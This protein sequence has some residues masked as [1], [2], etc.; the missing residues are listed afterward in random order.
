MK[1]KRIVLLLAVLVVFAV[2]MTSCAFLSQYH[3]HVW[4]GGSCTEPRVC[5]VCHAVDEKALGHAE[6]TVTGYAATCTEDGLSD[7]TVCSICNTVV[8]AQEVI[9]ALGHDI[10]VDAAIDADCLN[11]GLTAGEHCSRCD[12]KVD[13]E[14]VPALGHDIVKDAAKAPTCTENGLT[15]GEHCTRCD[16]NSAQEV[17]PALGH[18]MVVDA[19]KAPTCTEDGLKE[20][21]HCSRCD[22]KVAQEVD[23]A[24]GHNIVKDEAKA[25]TCTETGLTEGEHCTRCDGATVAQQSVAALGHKYE[26]CVCTVC[27]AVLPALG[28]TDSFDFSTQA[29]FDS[30]VASG[31]LGFVGNFRN[32]GDSFQFNA[33]STIQ[34]VA[35]ANSIVTLTGH[36]AQYGVFNVS[37][38]GEV[39]KMAGTLTFTVTEETKV[40]ISVGD[41]G[42][43]Y[44]YIKGIALEAYVDRTITED[45]TINFGSEGN[46]KDS[47]VDFSGIQIGDNGGNNSQVKNGSFDLLL[48]AGSKVVIHGYPGYTSYQLNDGEEITAEW[49]TYIALTDTV[50][51]VTPVNGSNYF[52]SIEITLHQGVAQVEA[53]PADCENAGYEAYYSCT[54][55]G[56]LTTKVVVD[57]LGHTE[58]TLAGKAATCTEAGLTAGK[59]CSVC[60]KVLVAQTEI[61]AKGHTEETLAGKESTCT[62]AGLTEGKKCSVCGEILIKQQELPLLE[63]SYV[64]GICACG[65]KDPSYVNYHLVGFI[66]GADHGCEGDYMNPGEYKFVDG[67]LVAKFNSDSYVFVKS[68]N[69]DG[70]NV[71][72]YLT[73]QYE[74]GMEA[75]FVESGHEKLFVPGNV[76][77]EFTLTV[78]ADGSLKV[79]LEYHVHSYSEPT[80]TEP[81]KCSCGLTQGEATGHKWVDASFD[82]PKTCSKCG[83]T[84]GAALV[85]VATA[86]G[87]KYQT[88]AEALEKGSEIVLLA[89]IE[90]DQPLVLNGA[91]TI[92]LNGYTLSYTSEVMGE[93]MITNYGTLVINDS[94][95][96]GTI[97]YNYVGA[98]DA[99]Y[100]KGN[101]TISNHGHLTINGGKITIA[102]L[103]QHAKYPIDNN[104]GSSDAV[105]VINGGHLYNY[106][107]SAIR[108]ICSA[109]YNNSVTINGGLVEGYC[110]I[111]MQN[112]G[113]NTV[114]GELT[115]TGGE[116]RTTAAA[117][118][119]GTSALQDVSSRIYAT[120]EGGAWSETSFVKISGGTFNE[121]VE[122]VDEAPVTIISG[123][124][125]NGKIE[126]VHTFVGATCTADGTCGCGAVGGKL[127]HT[128]QTLA[129]KDATCT[130]TGLTAG[131]KCSVCGETL[132][133]QVE[134]PAKDHAYETIYVW[135]ADN[136]Y[137]TEK[138]VCKNDASHVVEGETVTVSHITLNVTASKVTYTYH[139][140][141]QTK[142]VESDLALENNIATIDA[143]AVEGRVASHD[144]VK[145]SFHEAAAT[146]EFTIY[147]SEVDVWD[148]TVATEFAGGSGTEEDPYIIMTGAQLAYLAK[149]GMDNTAAKDSVY[150][151]GVYYKLGANLDLS[152]HQW[153]PIAMYDTAYNWT[154]FNGN[155]DGDNH[156]IIL[157]INNESIGY[158]LFA[159]LGKTSVVKNLTL[160]GNVQAAHRVGALVFITQN[161]A[162]IENV[163]N[164]ANV[165]GTAT[166]GYVG[167]LVGA[168]Q[169]A[170]TV[171]TGCVNYGI[172]NS[173]G[174]QTGGLV[175]TTQSL[176]VSNCVNF[177]EVSCSAGTVGGIAGNGNGAVVT[178][179]CNYGA[180]SGGGTIGG[181]VG[182]ITVSTKIYN[183]TNYGTIDSTSYNSGG[184]GGYM[185]EGSVI[186]GCVNYGSVSATNEKTGGIIGNDNKGT[187]S[188]CKNYGTITGVNNIGG[189]AGDA[190]N[191][192]TGCVNYG[193]VKGSCISTTID[194]ICPSDVTKTDCA[195]NGSVVISEHNLTHT[196]AKAATC[197]ADGNVAY[198]YCSVC[199]K[200]Y[201]ADGKVIENVVINKTGHFYNDGVTE[202]GVTTYT[203]SACGDSYTQSS[204]YTVTVNYVDLDGT[205]VAEPE[206]IE[207]AYGE[208]ATINA[209]TIDNLVPSHDYVKVHV[210]GD[211]S[212]TIYYSP[213]DVWD[214]E[215]VS[216]GLQGSG[217]AEDPYLIQ[218][219]ADL[220][221]VAQTV[222]ALAGNKVGFTGK[223]MRLTKSIDLNGADFRIGIYVSG[224]RKGFGAYL[225]GNNCSIRGLNNT[226]SF[227]G[228]LEAGYV[229]NLSVYGITSKNDAYVGGLCSILYNKAY[230][231]N[232]T[233]YV[234]VSGR[235]AVAG[236]AGK[237]YAG[238]TVRNC[239]NYGAVNAT[240]WQSG[241]ITGCSLGDVDGCINFGTIFTE[242]T[243][244]GGISGY[245][246]DGDN[247]K[248]TTTNC[249]NY[250]NVTAN[251]AAGKVGGIAGWGNIVNNCYNYGT[252]SAP[253]ATS[254]VGGV[255][256]YYKTSS[257]GCVDYSGFDQ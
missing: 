132:E 77:V 15:A 58:E 159:G 90:L 189:I 149:L 185:G 102:N 61:A 169:G 151:T 129:G 247:G 25:P 256:G 60:Q 113:K 162:R 43:S 150:G 65:Y 157:N 124:T 146:Y 156:R 52:Y 143:P 135:A 230:I 212:V 170:N 100:G 242:G 186:D 68:V 33:D 118:V 231:E 125:F 207:F 22:H 177:G 27:Q 239:V 12:H 255:C 104:S 134:I 42:A 223:Y 141:E 41:N 237:I 112:P 105:L 211:S 206:A 179:C 187:V 9:P 72:W 166:G 79:V 120:V 257:E 126:H 16:Y 248:G 71:K 190:S 202:N 209:K 198:D 106:N 160:Y 215:T 168:V 252:V 116:I 108:M 14:E 6:E 40:V 54:C 75:T 70:V 29:G 172:V 86:D 69:L 145:F 11:S 17:V 164:Y 31:K 240:T 47:I 78:N 94:A 36:S 44:S 87:V 218:S 161:G 62:E 144:Y 139:A 92:E 195:E 197:E 1:T 64:S 45:T 217:T 91:Y 201:D 184:I 119:N 213:V 175:G 163:T 110:A 253:N 227:I 196:D 128:E 216:T 59:K 229:K 236:I 96:N 51:T 131:K 48:K 26:N 114:N 84:E 4:E 13:Q 173:A 107:T 167:G 182:N 191:E 74:T 82:A 181:I 117:Y 122:F 88:L 250:G 73:T 219:A 49:Y 30:A 53:K 19:A 245:S 142:V 67:K 20:G 152:N 56:E 158:G 154:Y 7:G 121:N 165:T 46:Y 188:N 99:S 111:W 251:G 221:Y 81:G 204:K 133:A 205:K 98:N 199:K 233:S 39:T 235:G 89:N 21:S 137:Y 5:S 24:L 109:N 193:V 103:R 226:D 63:H 210:Q 232:V 97:N 38:N 83:A 174:K 34:F 180:I 28:V 194:Q 32:N 214:G 93:A 123:G 8:V 76:E 176:N 254:Y 241:G 140:G 200:N 2:A 178:G 85:A 37:L 130:E 55:H 57:A 127:G 115:I 224:G 95:V 225:D 80:C 220:A 23:P 238:T 222:N 246:K 244:V 136:S 243:D 208:I 10:V 101:Y 138:Q 192:I 35:P 18:D 228:S 155:F 147:Y 3:E 203:C 183:S 50:L 66:N 249:Y 234:T 171:M 153:T 148:G